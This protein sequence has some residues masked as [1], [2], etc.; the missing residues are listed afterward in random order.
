ME[1]LS[2][3]IIL[4]RIMPNMKMLD[5]VNV[6]ALAL[7]G[8]DGMHKAHQELFSHLD[9]KNGAILAIDNDYANLSP[10]KNRQKYT[11][12]QIFYYNLSE[13]KHL[14]AKTFIA[15]L[16]KDFPN[17]EQI[18]VGF[19][20]AFGKNRQAGIKELKEYFKGKVFVLEEFC[21]K[22]IPVHSRLIRQMLQDANLSQANTFLGRS[23]EIEAGHIKGQGLGK[24]AF[25][26]TI[27]LEKSEFLLPK[28]GV[29]VT[30]TYLDGVFYDSL[31][32]LGH[33]QTT[34]GSFASECHVLNKDFA[35]D[36]DFKNVKVK[37]LE[38]LRENKKFDNFSALKEQILLDI[39]KA[40][41]YFDL[42]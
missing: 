34:D 13:I 18:L 33:R 2:I 3:F 20:F 12:I 9:E 5:K 30:K 37:F 22:N 26:P 4:E 11:K 10:K 21:I 16:E 8:F 36:K 1:I 41:E 35:M 39:D 28:S 15:F 40:K 29:Y 19:D 6:K 32:F 25:V 7:G 38:F 17:L 42:K 24:K 31:T 27:N 23:Y 14:D